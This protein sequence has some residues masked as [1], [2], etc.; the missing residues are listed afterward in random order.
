MKLLFGKIQYDECKWKLCGDLKVVC[1]T[2]TGEVTR[3]HK[4]LLFTVRADS[5]NRNNYC[6]NKLWHK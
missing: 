2:V 6:V 3:V 4:T 1:G 5:R